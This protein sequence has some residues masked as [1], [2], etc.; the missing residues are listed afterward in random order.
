[1]RRIIASITLVFS[2]LFLSIIALAASFFYSKDIVIHR[3]ARFWAFLHLKMCGIRVL[4]RGKENILKPPYIIMCNHQSAL[5]IFVLYLSMPFLFKW[6]AK[7]QLFSIPVVGW[8]MKRADYISIDRESPR[9]GL[10]AI[11]DA[12]QKIRKG[13]NILIFPEGTRSKD[14]KLLPFKKGVFSL[15]LRAGVPVIPVGINGTG[16]LQPKESLMPGEKGVIY[17]NIGK[18]ILIRGDRSSDKARIMIEARASIEELMAE[19]NSSDL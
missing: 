15:A 14:G 17:V 9:E 6:I 12:A 11:N 13:L 18:P 7:R 1:M 4:I 19:K 8:I 3:L 10:K 16:K 2:T 5:D